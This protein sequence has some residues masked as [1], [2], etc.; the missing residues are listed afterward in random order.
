[1]HPVRLH[2][3]AFPMQTDR[4]GLVVQPNTMWHM[5]KKISSAKISMEDGE[6]TTFN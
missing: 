6:I 4:K 2:E 1:M 3:M 5:R